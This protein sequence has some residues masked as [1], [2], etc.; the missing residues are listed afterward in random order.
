MARMAINCNLVKMAIFFFKF[1]P[2]ILEK[3]LKKLTDNSLSVNSSEKLLDCFFFSSRCPKS[4]LMLCKSLFLKY[5][6]SLSRII[7][8]SLPAQETPVSLGLSRRK[9]GRLVKAPGERG[10]GTPGNF[11]WSVWLGS[12]S[13]PIWD[14]TI[15]FCGSFFRAGL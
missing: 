11:C 4:N 1:L 2:C 13:D 3:S 9:C 5:L 8:E 15:P 14:L 10:E 6:K 7:S 12:L